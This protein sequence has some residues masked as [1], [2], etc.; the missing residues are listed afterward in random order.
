MT[1]FPYV[2]ELLHKSKAESGGLPH[3][4]LWEDHEGVTR[5]ERRDNINVHMEFWLD[6]TG[7]E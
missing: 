6:L 1:I 7:S 4:L 5:N 3:A 2:F